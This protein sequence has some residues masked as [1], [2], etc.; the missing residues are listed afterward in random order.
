MYT[1]FIALSENS[2]FAFSKTPASASLVVQM[3][4][5][6]YGNIDFSH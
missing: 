3:I 4:P 2:E 5:A 1:Y 6:H